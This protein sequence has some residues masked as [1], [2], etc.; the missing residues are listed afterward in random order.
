MS[1]GCPKC[2]DDLRR[3]EIRATLGDDMDLICFCPLTPA[4]DAQ[5][6]RAIAEREPKPE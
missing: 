3:V 1:A 2:K 5:I 6:A 4:Q